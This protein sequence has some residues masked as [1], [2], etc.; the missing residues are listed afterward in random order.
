MGLLIL[1]SLAILHSD[2]INRRLE[3]GF[4]SLNTNTWPKEVWGGGVLTIDPNDS[5]YDN[6][7]VKSALF[8]AHMDATKSTSDYDGHQK[9]IKTR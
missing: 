5:S 6:S 2:I 7:P 4:D 9:Q 1:I 3:R 8:D